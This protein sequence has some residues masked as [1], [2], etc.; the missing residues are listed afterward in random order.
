[1]E[2]IEITQAINYMELLIKLY[3]LQY[4][5]FWIQI[6]SI[7]VNPCRQ[8]SDE[9]KLAW[10]RL[11][12]DI[13]H[14]GF[15]RTQIAN[16][17]TRYCTMHSRWTAYNEEVCRYEEEHKIETRWVPDSPEYNDALRLCTERKYRW[18]VD[19]LERL[20]VQH[21]FEMTKLGM[22]GVGMS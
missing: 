15:T 13:I 19:K 7:K 12:Y 21:L 6:I 2:P 20:V 10:N 14:N 1:M 5:L 3:H 16:V 22:N 11:D 18:A 9:A 8:Q 4:V 17:R